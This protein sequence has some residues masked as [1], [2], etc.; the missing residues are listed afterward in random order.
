M[1]TVGI[2]GLGKMGRPMAQNLVRAGLA[3]IVCDVDPSRV[4]ALVD[5][6]ARAAA[7]PCEVAE[8]A[9]VTVLSLPDPAAVR[10]VLLAPQTGLAAPGRSLTGRTIIDTS[11]IT[12]ALARECA[13]AV[14]AAGGALLDAPVTGGVAGAEKASLSFFVGGDPDAFAA[15]QDVFAALGNRATLI[16]PSGHGQAAKAVCQMLGSVAY[17]VNAEALAMIEALGVDPAKVAES[18]DGGR[19]LKTMLAQRES[20]RFGEEGYIAQRGKDLDCAM[21]AAGEAGVETPVTQAVHALFVEARKSGMGA[22]DPTAL[23][24]LWADSKAA[25]S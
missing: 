7:S 17:A 12:L 21:E 5:E 18:W 4:A 10:S 19:M 8:Q 6:G 22:M 25:L 23:F 1:K 24:L 11:T 9:K 14:T 16:G 13:A 20:G 3:V 2:V 15:H